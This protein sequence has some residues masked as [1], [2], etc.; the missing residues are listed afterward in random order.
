MRLIRELLAR[1]L[2]V[3]ELRRHVAALELQIIEAEQRVDELAA[4]LDAWV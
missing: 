4:K 2:G 1:V 3:P